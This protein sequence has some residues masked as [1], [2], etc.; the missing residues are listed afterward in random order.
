MRFR[1]AT[2][3]F[4]PRNLEAETFHGHVLRVNVY[5]FK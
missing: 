4:R 2:P 1:S 5:A 3:W